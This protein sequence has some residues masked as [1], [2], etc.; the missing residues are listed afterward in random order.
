[1]CKPGGKS[2]RH[3][4]KS[5]KV[6][7]GAFGID[8]GALSNIGVGG[9]LMC[10]YPFAFQFAERFLQILYLESHQNFPPSLP[11]WSWRHAMSY[12]RLECGLQLF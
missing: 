2:V 5:Q 7:R 11:T 4:K 8:Y 10:N 3:R 12:M 6:V 1:M 9:D